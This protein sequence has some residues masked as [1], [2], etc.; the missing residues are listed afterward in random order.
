MLAASDNLDKGRFGGVSGWP[1]R[2]VIG[3]AVNCYTGDHSC[4]AHPVAVQERTGEAKVD[5]GVVECLQVAGVD[6]RCEHCS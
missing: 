4:F 6:L 1:V 5:P 3:E 2:V